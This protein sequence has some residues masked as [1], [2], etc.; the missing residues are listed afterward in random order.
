[1]VVGMVG[2]ERGDDG[3]WSWGWWGMNARMVGVDMGMTGRGRG[4][5]GSW[6]GITG[7]ERED[8]G[9]GHGDDGAWSWG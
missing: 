4:D 8:G 5:D 7:H 9:C 1:M 3:V 2:H 6:L